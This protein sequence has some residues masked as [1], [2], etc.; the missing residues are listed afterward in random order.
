MYDRFVVY[1]CMFFVFI[2]FYVPGCLLGILVILNIFLRPFLNR[3]IKASF[4]SAPATI[5]SSV[6]VLL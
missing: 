6:R 2:G 3:L 1:V 4:C 5:S